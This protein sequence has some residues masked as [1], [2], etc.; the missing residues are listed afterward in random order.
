MAYAKPQTRAGIVGVNMDTG[1]ARVFKYTDLEFDQ[2][3]IA[4]RAL[5]A[6]LTV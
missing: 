1:G 5:L 3:E 4:Q 6:A 2:P